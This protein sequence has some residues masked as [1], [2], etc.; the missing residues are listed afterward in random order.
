M[1]AVAMAEPEAKAGYYGYNGGFYGYGHQLHWPGVY[2]YGFS[3]QCWG[4]RPLGKRSAEADADPG[5]YGHPL[6]Y[7]YPYAFGYPA[8]GPG[9][10]AHPGGATSFTQRSPQG[11]RG[12]RSAEADA[13]YGGYYGG[14]G[15]YGGKN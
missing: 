15:G 6:S 1:G 12:K 2:G 13:Y 9:I 11:L 10:A 7:G 8:Y 14:Y 4:C 3:S 5:F